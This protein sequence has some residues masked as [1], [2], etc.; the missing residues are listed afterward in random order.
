MKLKALLALP[1]FLLPWNNSDKGHLKNSN[2]CQGVGNNSKIG[3]FLNGN[4]EHNR[5]LTAGK[6]QLIFH[7]QGDICE[8]SQQ[9][10]GIACVFSQKIIKFYFRVKH[11]KMKFL[12]E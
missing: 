10:C 6:I 4:I 3:T 7:S 8:F 11:P 9:I 2:I 12:L 5:L 1:V